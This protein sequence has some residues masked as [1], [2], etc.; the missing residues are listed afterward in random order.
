[1]SNAEEVLKKVKE[2]LQEEIGMNQE[3]ADAK[4]N[5]DDCI[6]SDGTDDIIF[7]RYECAEG[8]LE[9]IKQ[10]EAV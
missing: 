9:Q 8:L 6:T 7:G 2:W 5:H 4:D 1:M 3:V 10:W